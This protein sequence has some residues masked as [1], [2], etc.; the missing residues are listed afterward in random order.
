MIFF[1]PQEKLL[2]KP[3]YWVFDHHDLPQICLAPNETNFEAWKRK[4]QFVF[5]PTEKPLQ[6]PFG[7]VPVEVALKIPCFLE[8]HE[9]LQLS[10]VCVETHKICSHDYVW[11]SLAFRDIQH[12]P[13]RRAMELRNLLRTGYAESWKFSYWQLKKQQSLA[14]SSASDSVPMTPQTTHTD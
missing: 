12:A 3:K 5:L 11:K 4:P 13:L 10:L 9:V 6:H 1:P 14:T 8:A 2:I 7:P